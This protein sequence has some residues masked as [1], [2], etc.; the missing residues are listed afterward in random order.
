MEGDES[1][2]AQMHANFS[3]NE[4]VDLSF[5]VASWIAFGRVT[6]ALELDTVC[7]PVHRAA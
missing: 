6:H 7:T 2:W 1:F 4:L 5:S 3:D